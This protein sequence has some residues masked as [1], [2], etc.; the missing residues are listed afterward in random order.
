MQ[1]I[2][3]PYEPTVIIIEMQKIARTQID[4]ILFQ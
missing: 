1:L 2:V 4:F 3:D